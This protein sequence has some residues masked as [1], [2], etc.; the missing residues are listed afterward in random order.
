MRAFLLPSNNYVLRPSYV[1]RVEKRVILVKMRLA[2]TDLFEYS[3]QGVD[4]YEIDTA[5]RQVVASIHWLHDRG[6]AHRDIKPEN[7][8]LHKG[9]FKLIDF[10]FSSPLEDFVRCGT[11]HFICPDKIV[12][13]WHCSPS[14]ASRRS[15]VY[16][17]GKLVLSIMWDCFKREPLV[18]RKRIWEMFHCDTINSSCMTTDPLRQA[19]IDVAVE[20]CG[21]LPPIKIPSLP[22]SIAITAETSG[23]VDSTTGVAPLQVVNADTVFA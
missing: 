13:A 22:A 12:K 21:K 23:A 8:V 4:F 5:F 3:K 17:F 11:Q 15:D 1:W 9:Q 10:D 18:Q 19:W 7:V 2:D 6:I 20:C 14:D 16:S